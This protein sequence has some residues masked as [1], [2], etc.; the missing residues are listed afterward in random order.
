MKRIQTKLATFVATLAISSHAFAIDPIVTQSTSESV[1][2]TNG[3]TTTT[4]KSPLP[5]AIS[6]AVT[7]INSDVCVVGVS[8]AA[9]TQILAISGG[10]ISSLK[11][12][13][14]HTYINI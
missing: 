1:T 14:R 12:C 8:G 10:T 6:P 11:T 3:S 9:Q 2:T 7:V 4:V 13:V 5:S